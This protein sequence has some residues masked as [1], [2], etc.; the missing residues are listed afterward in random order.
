MGGST[1]GSAGGSSSSP[2]SSERPAGPRSSRA[3]AA[4][5]GAGALGGTTAG[6]QQAAAAVP[7]NAVKVY[8]AGR[9]GAGKRIVAETVV[10]APVD[11]VWRVLT[12]YERL[13]D[14]VPNLEACERLPSPRPGRVLMRQRGC[15]QGVLW[16][17]EAEAVMEVEEVRGPL[18]RREA[19]FTMLEGDFK[20]GA[21][22][23][24]A[25]RARAW[26]Q[27]T[28]YGACSGSAAALLRN[29]RPPDCPAA[30]TALCRRK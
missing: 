25:G 2:A 26:G 21:A 15:S 30:A 23:G 7:P 3:G 16:R 8:E 29:A 10:Q 5:S 18:G 22:R 19:R 28:A 17:L 1:G 4:A 12:N 20:V 13:A 27:G 11:V 6:F 24:A 14:F 9:Q